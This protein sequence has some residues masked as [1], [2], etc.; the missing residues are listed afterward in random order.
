MQRVVQTRRSMEFDRP[1]SESSTAFF[2]IFLTIFSP[3]YGFFFG[4]GNFFPFGK[5]ILE[6]TFESF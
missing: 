2:S 6:N 1:P 5:G 3:F 4:K